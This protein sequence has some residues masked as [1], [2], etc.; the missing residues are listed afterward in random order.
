MDAVIV[1]T[2]ILDSEFRD[3]I[4][5]SDLIHDRLDRVILFKEYLDKSWKKINKRKCGF[6]WTQRSNRLQAIIES[7]SQKINN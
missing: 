1:D 4:N 3:E 5:N 6:D 7:I 2:P